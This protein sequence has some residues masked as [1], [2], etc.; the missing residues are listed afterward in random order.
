MWMKFLIF[1]LPFSPLSAV[2][3]GFCQEIHHQQLWHPLAIRICFQNRD[4]SLKAGAVTQCATRFL[5]NYTNEKDY[6]EIMN[7]NMALCLVQRFPS[8]QTL[9]IEIDVSPDAY[10][11]FHRKS[12]LKYKE[13]RFVEYFC[14]YYEKPL[15][16]EVWYT[17]KEG[18]QPEE[19]PDFL[20]LCQALD[21]FSDEMLELDWETVRPLLI[22]HLVDQF[23]MI[24]QLNLQF[25]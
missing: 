17:Y 7:L 12:L 3:V 16:L 11:P 6:W 13:G 2:V 24:E 23:P 14:F 18:I 10:V 22:Q 8:I 15:R 9:E 20:L 1:L 5:K 19:Y 21:Q 4:D 25:Y